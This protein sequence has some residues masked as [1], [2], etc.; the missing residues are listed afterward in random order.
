MCDVCGGTGFYV[1]DVPP[2]DPDFGRA[3]LCPKCGRQKI[4]GAVQHTVRK[5][6]GGPGDAG[7]NFAQSLPFQPALQQ[8]AEWG[9]EAE[10]GFAL[11][12]GKWGCGKSHLARAI[13]TRSIA[14]GRSGLFVTAE[15]MMRRIREGFDKK[16]GEEVQR[17]LRAVSTL[18]IDEVDEVGNS[19]WARGT[20]A[21]IIN[22]RYEDAGQAL[23]VMTTNKLPAELDGY[24]LSRLRDRRW[25]R[26]FQFWGDDVLDMREVIE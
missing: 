20:F 24:L 12:S 25:G 8:A 23:T 5:L 26:I 7:I 15:D 21:A 10:H 4:A 11:L 6:F 14:N 19:E 16:D 17:I 22:A 2:G 1:L 9:R 13:V 18:V 3:I